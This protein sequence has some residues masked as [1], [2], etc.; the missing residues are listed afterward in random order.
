M[1]KG[2]NVEQAIKFAEMA[3]K[4]NLHIHADFSLGH[5]GETK[6]SMDATIKL[7]KQMNPHTAQFQIM[8]PFK[9]TKFW[10]QLESNNL[11]N[12]VNEPDYSAIG[13]PSAEEI[14][15][16][17]KKLIANSILV[18]VTLRRSLVILMITYSIE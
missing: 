18:L 13:G 6:E 4:A 2:S 15:S 8:I 1:D 3:H 17:A 5:L 9:K 10:N 12:T 16:A 14:R 11:F 7:A